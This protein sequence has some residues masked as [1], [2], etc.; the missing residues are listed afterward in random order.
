MEQPVRFHL[1]FAC[2]FVPSRSHGCVC[3]AL[4]DICLTIPKGAQFDIS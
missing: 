4:K 1:L 2:T 3:L